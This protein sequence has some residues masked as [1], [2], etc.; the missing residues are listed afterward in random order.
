MIIIILTDD[1][2]TEP[3]VGQELLI[4]QVSQSYTTWKLGLCIVRLE[5][6]R[7]R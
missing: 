2:F 6:T 1:N 3:R 5:V 7:I 4:S